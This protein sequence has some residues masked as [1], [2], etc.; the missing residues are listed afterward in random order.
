MMKVLLVVL[1]Y[2]RTIG[3]VSSKYRHQ[4]MVRNLF[5]MNSDRY[6]PTYPLEISA[7]IS[8]S[9][10]PDRREIFILQKFGHGTPS[11]GQASWSLH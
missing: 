10:F 1:T 7:D 5:S 3:E 11:L 2:M 9:Y 4:F 8:I 6:C